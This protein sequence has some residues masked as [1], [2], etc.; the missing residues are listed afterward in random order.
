M[1]KTMLK[2]NLEENGLVDLEKLVADRVSEGMYIEFKRDNYRLSGKDDDKKKQCKEMLKDT[3]AF[4]NANGGDLIL[5]IDEADHTASKLVGIKTD[6]VDGLKRQMIAIIRNGTDPKISFS[7][8]TVHVRD[9]YHAFIIRVR[10]SGN[11]PHRV[12]YQGE[13]GGFWARNSGGAHEMTGP[14]IADLSRQSK[15]LTERI[16]AFRKERVEAISKN[17]CPVNLS[18]PRR[19]VFHFIP[20]AALLEFEVEPQNLVFYIQWMPILH[21]VGSQTHE[22][23]SDGMV[24]FD[25]DRGIPTSGYVQLYRNGI[26]ESVADDPTFFNPHDQAKKT[27]LF[28]HGYFREIPPRVKN[29]FTLLERLE[30]PPPVWFYMSFIGLEGCQVYSNDFFRSTGKPIKEKLLLMPGQEIE[31]Y[32]T[33]INGLIKPGFDKL[34]NAAGYPNCPL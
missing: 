25:R 29:Y 15:S 31:N 19:M 28:D 4:A 21:P 32:Q 6:D 8:H 17:E 5:G 18:S 30:V 13:Q 7:I 11:A 10:P 12:V 34:W 1:R 23:N 16:E 22:H 9:D 26:V 3:S 33:D 20:E 14:E 27:R 2:K 24:S